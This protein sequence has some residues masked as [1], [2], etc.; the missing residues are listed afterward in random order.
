MRGMSSAATAAGI[1]SNTRLKQPASC[2]AS[3]SSAIRDAAAA[4]RPCAR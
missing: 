3:A 2:S 1:A 4:V